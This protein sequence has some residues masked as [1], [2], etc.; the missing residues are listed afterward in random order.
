MTEREIP[1]TTPF[2]LKVLTVAIFL[3]V[4]LFAGVG[5]HIWNLYTDFKT[6]QTRDIRLNELSGI[7]IHFDEVLTM[8]ARMAAVTGDRKWESRYREF[9][10]VLDAA[11]K[12]AARLA[13]TVFAGEAASQTDKANLLLVDMETR[14]F[15]MVRRGDREQALEL[16]FSEEYEKQKRIY[17]EGIEKISVVLHERSDTALEAQSKRALAGVTSIFIVIPTL[18]LTWLY[19][20]RAGRRYIAERDRAEEA[21]QERER[22]LTSIFG[23]IQD[24][25]CVLDTE[26][27]IVRVNQT[28]EKWYS[29]ALPLTGRKCY[30]AYHGRSAPCEICPSRQ[31]LETGETAYE[32]VPKIGA[33]E[34]IEGWF[35]LY[36]FPLHDAVTGRLSGVIEYVRDITERVRSEERLDEFMNS[37]TDSFHLLDRD[38]NIIE[39]N[40]AALAALDEPKEEVVGRHLLDVYPFLGEKGR[41]ENFTRVIDTGEPHFMEDTVTHPTR[42]IIHM[43]VKSF[44]VGDG[45]G[46]IATDMTDRVR[47]EEERRMLEAQLQHTQKL[48]SLGVLA[49]GIAHDFNNLLTGILGHAD[50]ALMKMS[51]ASPARDNVKEI[52]T[53]SRRA[54]DLCS[55]MLA[56][57]GK[58]RF[59]VEAISLSE[60]VREMTHLLKISISKKAVLRLDFADDLPAV[61]ADATQIRQII[62]NLITNASEAIGDISGVISISTG[63][64]ECDRDYLAET[65]LDEQLEEGVY[66]YIEVSDSGC[67]M[68]EETRSRIFDP[69]FTTKFTGRGL[70]LAAVLGIIRGHNGA[71]KVYSE[72][73]KGTTFKA[74]FP[75]VDQ[76]AE[77]ILKKSGG[78]GDWRGSGSVLLVDD[79]ETVRVVAKSMLEEAG[80]EVLTAADGREAVE[81]FEKHAGEITL[82]LLDMTMP[83]MGGEEAFR[84]IRRIRGDARV[85]LSSG[86]NE[87]EITSRF[88]G[89]RLAGFIQKPYQYDVLVEKIRALLGE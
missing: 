69:F 36:S 54:A 88:S 71:I 2:P 32:I 25:I 3:T 81:I 42:G 72:P 57:S 84:E 15:E 46:I 24:G 68:D 83:H 44:K 66:V 40:A 82:V 17:T 67:G 79:E 45:L 86:Y 89:K 12:E 49:G 80:F 78:I 20:L 50:L 23:S 51:P 34:E 13:P 18:L 29:H 52:R 77:P 56:Y 47:V 43:T 55:Q 37:A 41:H 1:S 9:E 62:M 7:I 70:G 4:F 27:N 73:G 48:E 87:Q 5:W 22:F 59:V 35:D 21:V 58:G 10:P 30:E 31:T 85:I 53:T 39:I 6:T 14:A 61:E 60:V 64:M 75:A 16:L 63:A 28:M 8:S 76:P 38:L 19:V 33:D 74:L 11:I 26:F 65:Y